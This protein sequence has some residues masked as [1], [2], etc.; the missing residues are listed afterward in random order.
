MCLV[1]QKNFYLI[2]PPRTVKNGAC[3]ACEFYNVCF[4]GNQIAPREGY[5]RIH[6]YSS[7]TLP[8]INKESCL[9]GSLSN[10]NGACKEGYKGILCNSCSNLWVK[11][12]WETCRSCMSNTTLI[13]SIFLALGR[14]TLTLLLIQLSTVVNIKMAEFSHNRN[15]RE[16]VQFQTQTK[17][18]RTHIVIMYT[19]IRIDFDWGEILKHVII[20]PLSLFLRFWCDLIQYDCE[21][22]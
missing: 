18:F 7:V 10:P 5:Y 8:C 11:L 4:G 20:Q 12:D 21:I 14:L 1:C 6:K 22:A 3:L 13:S 19:L 16:L 15:G 9:G 2:E 17:F